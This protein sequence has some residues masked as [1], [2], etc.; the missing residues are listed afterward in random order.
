MLSM[1]HNLQADQY[2]KSLGFFPSF[3]C[4]YLFATC[5]MSDEAAAG[6]RKRPRRTQTGPTEKKTDDNF[7][8]TEISECDSKGPQVE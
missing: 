7:S 2:T 6:V 1:C 5:N 8:E 4:S 3:I